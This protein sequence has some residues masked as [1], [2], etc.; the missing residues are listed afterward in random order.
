MI[1]SC[2]GESP[3]HLSEGLLPA[4]PADEDIY[5]LRTQREDPSFRHLRESSS[6]PPLQTDSDACGG[7]TSRKSLQ[8]PERLQNLHLDQKEVMK[9]AATAVNVG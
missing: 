3:P 1:I 9:A 4:P 7:C 8:S 2:W 6:A 5:I